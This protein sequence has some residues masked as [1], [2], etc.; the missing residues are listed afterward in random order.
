MKKAIFV[1]LGVV[2]VMLVLSAH[3]SANS[4]EQQSYDEAT[5]EFA[6]KYRIAMPPIPD[7]IMLCGELVPQEQWEVRERLE[8][9]VL[10]NTYWQSNTLLL[11]KR[12]GK[13]F[14]L[15]ER[16]LREEGVPDDFKYL[17]VAESG[18]MPAVSPAGARGIW[19]FMKSTGTSYGLTITSEVDERYHVEKATRAA[20]KYLKKAKAELN[21]WT[22]AAAAYNRGLNGIR[23]DLANQK[24]D[25]YYDLYLN[26]ETSRYVFR[27]I[28]FKLLFE[29]PNGFGFV[30]NE[31]QYYTPITTKSLDVDT[32]IM[33]LAGFAKLNGTTYKELKLLNPWLRDDHLMVP[34]GE[35]FVL[36]VPN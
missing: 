28:A 35:K 19:Q 8:R 17:A 26:T 16:V 25:N 24:V 29:N 14:P 10:S 21:S 36:E 9:E 20:C 27:I 4:E 5:D 2:A 7:T 12:S 3:E 30:L 11:L 33:D 13:Y 1:I 6:A 18:L 22:L 15:I 32:T 31:S 34:A 23:R